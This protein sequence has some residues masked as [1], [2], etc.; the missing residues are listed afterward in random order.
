VKTKPRIQW[1][2]TCK[3]I[4]I[5]AVVLGHGIIS[6]SLYVYFFHMPLFFCLSGYL[7]RP[8]IKYLEFVRRKALHLLVPY[9]SFIFL[10]SLPV[11]V[12]FAF[13]IVK[14]SDYSLANELQ[15]FTLKLIY[16]GAF[17]SESLGT[18][19][20]IT[21]LFFTQQLYHFL[22]LKIPSKKTLNYIL[23]GAYCLGMLQH[24]VFRNFNLFWSL[25]VVPMALVCYGSGHWLATEE[26]DLL[27]FTKAAFLTV[28]VGFLANSW[29][30]LD[31]LFLMKYKYYGLPIINILMAG[32]GIVITVY[33]ADLISKNF[34]IE[35]VV[36][37]IGSASMVILYVHQILLFVLKKS[38]LFSS[39]ILRTAIAFLVPYLLFKFINQFQVLRQFFLGEWPTKK[40]TA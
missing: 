7:Y 9:L 38:S 23:L 5:I 2:D 18:F 24:F 28:L 31:L 16:G 33:L 14:T 19:W 11:Y 40:E 22:Y 3:G 15:S 21:C 32:S 12:Y 39:E 26:I 27:R 17:L 13:Q 20:F 25:D 34:L 36:K 29:G 10:L 37:E 8:H 30:K 6:T 35:K 1:I 4:G